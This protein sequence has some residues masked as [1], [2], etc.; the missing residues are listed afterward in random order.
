MIPGGANEFLG[1]TTPFVFMDRGPGNRMSDPR[2][3]N[4]F[5]AKTYIHGSA[6]VT[7]SSVAGF[8]AVPG[9]NGDESYTDQQ[10]LP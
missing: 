3:A 8:K 2:M 1:C 10:G 4:S 6:V 9:L 7:Q 5:S